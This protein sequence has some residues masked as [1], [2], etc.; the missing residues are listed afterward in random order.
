[1]G[2]ITTPK[3]F[4]RIE[5]KWTGILLRTSNRFRIYEAPRPNETNHFLGRTPNI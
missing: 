2:M 1:M 4:K 3:L 5:D